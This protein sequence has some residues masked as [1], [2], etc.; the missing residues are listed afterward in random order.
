MQRASNDEEPQL[1]DASMW[2]A[3]HRR[4]R[5]WFVLILPGLV[6]L[7]TFNVARLGAAPIE[8]VAVAGGTFLLAGVIAGAL[9]AR[10]RRRIA[11]LTPADPFFASSAI[12][13]P[14]SVIGDQPPWT[15]ALA[16]GSPSQL[17]AEGV[18]WMDRDGFHWVCAERKSHVQIHLR[19]PEVA[20]VSL[21][22]LW[23]RSN[24][25]GIATSAGQRVGFIVPKLNRDAVLDAL[26]AAQLPM[27]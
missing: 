14:E 12:L 13:V 2:N 20:A 10:T 5:Q 24:G 18:L 11:H 15:D 27:P 1:L 7:I 3:H 21:V 22:H 26:R 19:A 9:V 25:L 23:L 8:L 17:G 6:L 4:R 16:G